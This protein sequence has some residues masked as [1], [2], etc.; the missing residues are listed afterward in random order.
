[1][2]QQGKKSGR[3]IGGDAGRKVKRQWE[4]DAAAMPQPLT[5]DSKETLCANYI[6]AYA[7]IGEDMTIKQA[8]QAINNLGKKAQINVSLV[9]IC[10]DL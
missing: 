1:M 10:V 5:E 3:C 4:K 8:K 6:A 2:F 7:V 9:E